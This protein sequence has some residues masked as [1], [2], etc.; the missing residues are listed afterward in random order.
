MI[1]NLTRQQINI[2]QSLIAFGMDNMNTDLALDILEDDSGL[3]YGDAQALAYQELN[4]LSLFF[5]EL[6]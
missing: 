4:D 1:I 2:I 3:G 5:E 6:M